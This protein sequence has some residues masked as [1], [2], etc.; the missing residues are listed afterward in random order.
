MKRGSPVLKNKIEE[1]F[2]L[3]CKF[4]D[5]KNG[6]GKRFIVGETEVALFKFGD[7]IYALNNVCPHQQTAL[8]YD[9]IIE[10]GSVVCPAHGW[11]FNLKT[12]KKP[13]GSR[14]LDTYE[15]KIVNEDIYARVIPKELNW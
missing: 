12:G 2:V 4:S 9:G 1:G 11:K 5:L 15:V 6:E 10:D 8:L 14:G 3:I 13:G 7:K